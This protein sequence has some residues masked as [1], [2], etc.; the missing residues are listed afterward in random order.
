MRIVFIGPPGAGKGTQAQKLIAYLNIPHLSTGDMLRDARARQTEVGRLAEEYMSNGQLVPDPVV[1]K[2]VGERLELPDC[3]RGGL[4]DGFPRTLGQAQSLDRY[5]DETSR[6]LDLV[7]ELNVPH[8]ELLRRL[9][10][11]GRNDDRPE[12]IRQRLV[13]YEQQTRP[14]L[15][16][17]RQRG[18]LRSIDGTGDPDAV[19]D[20]IKHVLDT[21]LTNHDAARN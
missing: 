10:G 2:I 11:R 1:L 20:R 15:E 18:L 14:L 3:Q 5:L 4:F 6:P 7:L 12:V 21:E 13:G 8:E 9:A 16:Y 19:F 17:Y